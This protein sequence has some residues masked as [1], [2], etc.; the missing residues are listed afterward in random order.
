MKPFTEDGAIDCTHSIV[1]PLNEVDER[2][3]IN[4]SDS[5][6]QVPLGPCAVKFPTHSA[7]IPLAA[8]SEKYIDC[9]A[10]QPE[11]ANGFRA[12]KKSPASRSKSGPGGTNAIQWEL[13][14]VTLS[15]DKCTSQVPFIAPHESWT[16]ISAMHSGVNPDTASSGIYGTYCAYNLKHTP[17]GK[18]AI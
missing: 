1:K 9:A 15:G 7:V 11:H 10:D 16:T 8:L 18:A 5:P 17:R 2:P 13:S 4:R 12:L 6:L 3:L 14:A